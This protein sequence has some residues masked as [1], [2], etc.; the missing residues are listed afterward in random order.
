VC[1][2]AS[3]E[4]SNR[5]TSPDA[6]FDLDDEV[7][8][9]GSIGESRG[10]GNLTYSQPISE[11]QELTEMTIETITTL[12]KASIVIRNATSRDRYAKAVTYSR[13]PFDD[14]FDISHVEHKFPRICRSDWLAKRLGRAITRRREFYVIVGITGRNSLDK[15][16]LPQP[17]IWPLE[18]EIRCTKQS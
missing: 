16:P 7:E 3:G 17:N 14:Q 6:T 15:Q 18:S 1:S 9:T 10:D 8:S 13:E 2:I 4:R 11:I 12:F 5:T